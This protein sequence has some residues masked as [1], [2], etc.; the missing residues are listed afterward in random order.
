MAFDVPRLFINELPP[1]E[2]KTARFI[3]IQLFQL[4]MY[5]SRFAAVLSLFDY[6]SLQ[7][8]EATERRR[9]EKQKIMGKPGYFEANERLLNERR[10]ALRLYGEWRFI[11]ARD[12]A[13]A[14]YHFGKSIEA[15]KRNLH[16]CPTLERIV[17]RDDLRAATNLHR[18]HF[19]RFEAIRHAVGHE[20]QL[21]EDPA[22]FEENSFT[23][24]YSLP[25]LTISEGAPNTVLNGALSG[26]TYA[27]TIDRKILSYDVSSETLNN[28]N[29]VKEGF[30]IAFRKTENALRDMMCRRLGI[31]TRSEVEHLSRDG[32]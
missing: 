1:A 27:V 8:D 26:R 17:Q 4:D 13:M 23:G 18:K 21:T 24:A 22:A 10:A 31:P 32:G 25:G 30:Y 20:G 12:G 7:C 2:Q 6:S 15:L 29:E 16:E 9:V 3:E 28:L 11:A 5:V 19:P 14:L